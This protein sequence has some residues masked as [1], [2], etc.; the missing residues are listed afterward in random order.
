LDFSSSLVIACK[1]STVSESEPISKVL[2]PE[3]TKVLSRVK[4][5]VLSLES[6]SGV[7]WENASI[8]FRKQTRKNADAVN[9]FVDIGLALNGITP[10]RGSNFEVSKL[11]K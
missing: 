3:I 4:M 7:I 9:I 5:M 2:S 11:T 1:V 8:E 6:V 10:Q